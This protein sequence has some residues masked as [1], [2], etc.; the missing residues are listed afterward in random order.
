LFIQKQSKKSNSRDRFLF[1]Y[2]EQASTEKT[3]KMCI[4]LS[5]RFLSSKRKKSL[6]VGG[7]LL[8]GQ[9]PVASTSPPPT[10]FLLFI[11]AAKKI[12]TFSLFSF[13]VGCCFMALC[14]RR[15]R[16]K[17]FECVSLQKPRRDGLM[18]VYIK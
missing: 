12:S 11:F 9:Q 5:L 6:R 3:V 15:E 17:L 1:I 10:L 18:V 14:A 7:T 13:V 2:P 16:E 8:K 4:P